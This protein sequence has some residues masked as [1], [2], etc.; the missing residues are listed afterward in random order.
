MK[1]LVYTMFINNNRPSFHLWWKENL[2]EHRKVSK[3]YE[4]GC[5]WVR[6]YNLPFLLYIS[7]LNIFYA[8]YCNNYYCKNFNTLIYYDVKLNVDAFYELKVA[9]PMSIFLLA[10]FFEIWIKILIAYWFLYFLFMF[11]NNEHFFLSLLFLN[12]N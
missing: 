8:F 4:T 5:R 12:L 11:V 3:Y 6:Y 10:Y 1:Q 9:E 2:V 7:F